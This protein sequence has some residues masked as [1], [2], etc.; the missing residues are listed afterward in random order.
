M[1]IKKVKQEHTIRYKSNPVLYKVSVTSRIYLETKD[2]AHLSR[3]TIVV[4]VRKIVVL[5]I[6][7]F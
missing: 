5:P 3:F 6:E 2:S 1:K 4:P 7:V